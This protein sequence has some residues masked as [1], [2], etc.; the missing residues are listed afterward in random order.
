MTLQQLIYV[1]E[2]AK[3]SSINKAAKNLY[4]SQPSLSKS[5]LSLEH[6]LNVTLFI[7]NKKGIT[8]TDDGMEF[9]QYARTVLSQFNNIKLL[10]EAK[11]TGIPTVRITT[12]RHTF[13]TEALM[14]F[15]NSY[16]DDLSKFNI[17]IRETPPQK[18]YK[19]ILDGTSN[20]GMVS[21]CRTNTSFWSKFFENN[22]IDAKLIFSCEERILLRRDHPLLSEDKITLD[23]LKEFPLI[24]SFE[25]NTE[26]PNFDAE[27][28]LLKYKE[29]PKIIHTGERSVIFSL[30]RTTNCI[31]FAT[32]D[33]SVT[34]FYPDLVSLP[35]PPP[36]PP[37]MWGHYVIYLKNRPM[38]P[39]EKAFINVMTKI[40]KKH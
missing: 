14:D 30:L 10:Y 39:E 11:N 32:T 20:I 21:L 36:L 37:V 7:R 31:F 19:D 22:N 34:T 8:I 1:V 24:Q 28:D 9:I 2:V 23:R 38:S 18:V 6:E 3:Y 33:M 13:V 26:L 29:F 40:P 15:C 17:S 25:S 4:V 12:S 35:L 16:L 27:I 5:I